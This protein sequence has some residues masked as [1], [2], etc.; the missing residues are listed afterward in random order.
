VAAPRFGEKNKN[1]I[2]QF[3]RFNSNWTNNNKTPGVPITRDIETDV[4]DHVGETSDLKN[5]LVV[6]TRL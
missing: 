3:K 5:H 4:T 2:P 6:V 1:H